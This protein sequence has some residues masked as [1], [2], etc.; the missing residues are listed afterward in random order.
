M[1]G[2][3]SGPPACNSRAVTNEFVDSLYHGLTFNIS[4]YVHYLAGEKRFWAVNNDYPG[5]RQ[6][7]YDKLIAY[8]QSITPS[9]RKQINMPGYELF[10]RHYF[11]I[12]RTVSTELKNI[13]ELPRDPAKPYQTRCR[14]GV[15]IKPK[16]RSDGVAAFHA[17]Y[18]AQWYSPK[19]RGASVMAVVIREA[20]DAEIERRGVGVV[21]Q[22]P[23]NFAIEKLVGV[24][25]AS[26]GPQ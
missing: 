13:Q 22:S 23:A 24:L 5:G 21:R 18:T 19:M 1:L 15:V 16:G 26:L 11:L 25:A 8:L 7:D 2:A 10:A 9:Y 4:D 14:A 20:G 6:K 12:N 17:V 3:C